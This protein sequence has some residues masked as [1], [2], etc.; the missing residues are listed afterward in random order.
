MVNY[1]PLL[2]PL[3]CHII[4]PPHSTI[5]IIDAMDHIAHAHAITHKQNTSLSESYEWPQYPAPRSTP[6]LPHPQKNV[7]CS[8]SPI[9]II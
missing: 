7:Y 9:G 8:E 6:L 5:R 3:H 4:P 2:H 1:I